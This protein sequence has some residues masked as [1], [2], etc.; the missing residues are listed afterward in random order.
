MKTPA[1]WYRKNTFYEYLF[2]PLSIIWKVSSILRK[3]M[4]I[5]KEFNTNI[6]CVGNVIAGGGG[7]TPIIV[8]LAKLLKKEKP[9]V[10]YKYYKTNNSKQVKMVNLK[11]SASQV[12]DEPIFV[13]KFAKT[14]VC[15]NRLA[16]CKTAISKGA[17]FI[18]LDDG[19]QDHSIKKD[20]VILAINAKQGFG[21]GKIIPSGPLRES[22]V[23]AIN[24]CDCIFLNGNS[25]NIEKQIGNSK[26][27]IYTKTKLVG[28]YNSIKK[29][30]LIGFAGI[31]HPS[32]FFDLLVENNFKLEKKISF[33]DHFKY[34]SEQILKIIEMAK[35]NDFKIVT[36]QKDFTKIPNDL[37]IF[38]KPIE[39]DI[40]FNE[41]VFLK[42]LYNKIGSH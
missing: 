30:K 10:I 11:S 41:K 21:N 29:Y 9:L 20:F 16:G 4:I 34:T 33:P 25:T 42:L 23:S 6:I 18:L 3:L 40:T 8:K 19:L 15:S 35:E 36:T 13:S 37:K 17:K 26:K 22:I 12:G 24:K 27:I 14:L 32:N 2:Y 7:K 38:I 5:P 39:I 31:A 1:F 28:N